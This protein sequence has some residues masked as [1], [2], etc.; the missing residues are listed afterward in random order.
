MQRRVLWAIRLLALGTA[1]VF[2]TGAEPAY[3]F[4][5]DWGGLENDWSMPTPTGY[6]GGGGGAGLP[7]P[8]TV[9]ECIARAANN[10]KCRGCAQTYYNNGMPKPYQVCAWY[11]MSYSCSCK[12]AN[13]ANCVSVGSCTYYG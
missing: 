12:G 13:T 6:S 7:N 8:P 2:V 4:N 9:T 11:S 1:F 5:Q 10:Q 3:A